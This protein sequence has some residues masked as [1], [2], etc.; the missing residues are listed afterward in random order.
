MSKDFLVTRCKG[1]INILSVQIFCVK[2]RKNK[3]NREKPP[4]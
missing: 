1:T 3:H 4:F 2:K